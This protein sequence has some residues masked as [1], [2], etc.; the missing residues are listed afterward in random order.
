VVTHP[1]GVAAKTIRNELAFE[2]PTRMLQR[3]M[4]L[5]VEQ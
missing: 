4:A 1:D 5:L 3:R 2:V